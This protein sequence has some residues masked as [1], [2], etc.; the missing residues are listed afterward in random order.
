MPQSLSNVLLHQIFST[1]HRS[2]LIDADIEPEL[3]AYMI[4][5]FTSCGS[6]V[7]K[8]GGVADHVHVLCTLPRVL[9]ISDLFEKIK[10]T[11]SKWIK[12]KGPKY[13]DF[14]WQAGFG[15]FSVSASLLDVVATY[16]ANQKEHHKKLT[17][18]DE[19][20]EF[21]RLH[22]IPYDERYLWD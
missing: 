22:N 15:V 20:R 6:Y 21:L 10:K 7:H 8:I 2:P 4:S 18:Q 5:V 19:Y 11:S 16:I 3:Y 1:K 13:R 12:T 9:S 14:S 17:F